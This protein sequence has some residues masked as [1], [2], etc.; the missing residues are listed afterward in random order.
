MTCN[1]WSFDVKF[2]FPLLFTRDVFSP[3]NQLLADLLAPQHHEPDAR[4]VIYIDA[5]VTEGRTT[6]IR[7]IHAWF[8]TQ[9]PRRLHLAAAP[10]IVAGGEAL[11]QDLSIVERFARTCIDLGLCRH[12][13]VI[14]IGGGAVLD[15]IGQIGRAHV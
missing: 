9:T 15:A 7:D 14:T 5:S 11:K 2:S 4:A 6:L 8:A 1:D 3:D 10:E 13:Y 12:S